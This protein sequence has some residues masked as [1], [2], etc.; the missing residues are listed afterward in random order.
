MPLN[1]DT[2]SQYVVHLWELCVSDDSLHGEE[3]RRAVE[4]LWFLIEGKHSRT[5][6]IL[7]NRE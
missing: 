1:F 6:A 3:N 7:T 2:P 4:W 5:M